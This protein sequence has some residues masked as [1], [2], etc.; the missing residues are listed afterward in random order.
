MA[1][2]ALGY[3]GVYLCRKNLAVACR[4][5]SKPFGATKGRGRRP[6]PASGRSRTRRA[7]S[8]RALRR[9]RRGPTGFR[10]DLAAVAL[11]GAAGALAPGL[12]ALERPLQLNRFAGAGG[13]GRDVQARSFVVRRARTGTV[14]GVLSGATSLGGGI[15][16]LFARKSSTAAAS[17]RAVMGVPSA[18][19]FAIASSASF[20]VRSG[21][22]AE[23]CRSRPSATSPDRRRP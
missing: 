9:P 7:R 23:A 20:F 12:V 17:W 18:A 5:S 22:R 16:T 1:T 13:V 15:A 21:P 11:F 19:T 6:S 10:V 3:V 2:L 4:S 8:S 14:V